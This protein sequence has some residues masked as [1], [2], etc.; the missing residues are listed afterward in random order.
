M[1]DFTPNTRNTTTTEVDRRFETL[2]VNF[3]KI[4][5]NSMRRSTE[6][7]K[8]K[9]EYDINQSQEMGISGLENNTFVAGMPQ[10]NMQEIMASS[11]FEA[12][13]NQFRNYKNNRG[14]N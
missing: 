7:G 6:M 4:E 5:N 11:G 12:I 3:E 10:P 1:N 14:G 2:P 13:L 8:A 9:S